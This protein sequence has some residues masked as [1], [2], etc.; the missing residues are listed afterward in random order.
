MQS[1]SPVIEIPFKKGL[2][3][4]PLRDDAWILGAGVQRP[5]IM[6]SRNWAP[7]K[8]TPNVQFTLKFDPYSCVSES[9][10]NAL[11]ELLN[12]MMTTDPDVRVILTNLKMLDGNGKA[13]LS[14][15]FLAVMS[16]T[17]PGVGNSQAKV[18][19]TLR[20]YGMVGESICP[21]LPEMSQ[22]EYFTLTPEMKK[23]GLEF[24]KFFNPA[25]Y[26]AV[27]NTIVPTAAQITDGLQKG[28]VVSCVGSSYLGKMAGARLYRNN[29]QPLYTHQ[30]NNIG[31]RFNVSV[32]DET[33]K[34]IND[35]FD[36]YEPFDKPYYEQY[37]FGYAKIIYLTKKKMT[38]KYRIFGTSSIFVLDPVER[39]LVPYGSG[40]V[41][42]TIEGVLDYGEVRE[43]PNLNAL[44]AIAPLA[45]WIILDGAWDKE[46]WI[47]SLNK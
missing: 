10:T 14:A 26:E 46:A 16:G 36:T 47:N 1:N 9:I 38:M 5:F 19:D 17:I 18:L 8:P 21:T 4:E 15:R 40:K 43:V 23:A 20:K 11:E 39:K 22:Q 28:P 34:I 12:F 41:F 25:E 2:V 13:K 24:Y 31:Q 42:K 6:P 37:P 3:V 7:Y 30:I 33:V 35:V 32:F 44:K 27:S 45:D 29:G